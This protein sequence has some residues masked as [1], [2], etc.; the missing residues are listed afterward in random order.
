MGCGCKNKG[1]QTPQQ[2]QQA[3]Q[4]IQEAQK[5]QQQQVKDAV[6]KTIEKYYT[7]QKTN[8]WVKS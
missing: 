4:Q 2:A 3:Q 5:T 6:K 1:T 7:A 8:G